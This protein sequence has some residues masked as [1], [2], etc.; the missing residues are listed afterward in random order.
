[1]IICFVNVWL[2]NKCFYWTDNFL[3]F[4]STVSLIE[5]FYDKL[6]SIQSSFDLYVLHVGAQFETRDDN[7]PFGPH[8]VTC[9]GRRN[10][11]VHTISKSSIN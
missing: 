8:S 11:T 3:K 4:E 9:G 1:M 5:F 7:S 6:T 2:Y 10:G